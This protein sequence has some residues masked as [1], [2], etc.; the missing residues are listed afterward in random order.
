[1]SSIRRKQ[2]S[3][4][5]WIIMLILVSVGLRSVAFLTKQSLTHDEA[6]S[7]LAASCQQAKFAE[8][9]FDITPKPAQFWHEYLT[10]TSSFCF[11]TIQH[12]LAHFDRHPPLYF[13]LLHISILLFGSTLWAGFFLNIIIAVLT[14]AIFSRLACLVFC[15][16][17]YSLLTIFTY[18][19]LIVVIFISAEVRQYDLLL[20]WGV[21]LTWH[22]LR[23]IKLGK[24][25]WQQA[26]LLTLII[27]GGFL[28]HYYFMLIVAGCCLFLL[29]T[30]LRWSTITAIYLAIIIG[31][32]IFV[33]LYPN[34]LF[35]IKN[36]T[37][38]ETSQGLSILLERI[39][40]LLIPFTP[41]LY[42]IIPFCIWLI[43]SKQ[44]HFKMAN[45]IV[46]RYILFLFIWLSTIMITLYITGITPL[47]AINAKYFGLIWP[48]IAFL[49]ALMMRSSKRP[50]LYLY[51]YL[52]PCLVTFIFLAQQKI[53]CCQQHHPTETIFNTV[54][55]IVMDNTA[56]GILLPFMFHVPAQHQTIA[57]SQTKLLASS[58]EWLSYL[59]QSILYL[60][61]TSGG[62]RAN[63]LQ[64]KIIV[65]LEQHGYTIEP[66][67][68]DLLD[69]KTYHSPYVTFFIANRS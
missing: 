9:T 21:I 47:H 57:S 45:D 41:T 55:L 26:I 27:T 54:D 25:K 29:F 16:T 48:I 1:M 2:H 13:W 38:T 3:L 18:A 28:T 23:I 32:L 61:D 40:L 15:K 67:K 43:W 44:T 52:L 10:P 17:R 58:D 56:R 53:S 14:F 69:I 50:S 42:I 64:S 12:G 62:G 60:S 66:I 68:G 59:P 30:Q 8:I 63:D 22:I 4:Q 36:A 39:P 11:N 20:F 34:F 37:N 7:Y 51:F 19:T 65:L 24:F 33:G 35:N 31:L 5:I 46:V 49:P 6:I